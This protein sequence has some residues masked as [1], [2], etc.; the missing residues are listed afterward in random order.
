MT[1]AVANRPGDALVKALQGMQGEVGKSLPTG[2]SITA[3][4]FVRGVIT[5]VRENPKL[6]QCDKT[7]FLLACLQ[8]ARLGLVPNDGLGKAWLIPYGRQAQLQLGYQG[9]LELARRSGEISMVYAATVHEHD[10][11]FEYELGLEPKLRHVPTT[12][13]EKG[14]L[15]HAYAVAHLKDGGR[16]FVVL[17]RAELDKVKNSVKGKG[18]PWEN[19][20]SSMCMKTCIRRLAKWLPLSSGFARAV[21]LEDQQEAGVKPQYDAEVI[22]AVP[23]ERG[24]STFGFEEEASS[25]A[26]Q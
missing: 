22:E 17:G 20:F 6:A 26:G 16:Q 12:Q 24:S 13:P 4:T 3:K 11:V 7:S 19:F 1:R 14:D 9:M 25:G 2:G 15:T 23:V 5:A 10:D 18:G 21:F 8:S